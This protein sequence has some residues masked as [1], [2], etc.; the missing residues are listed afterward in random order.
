MKSTLRYSLIL[1]L[2]VVCHSHLVL[3]SLAG[4]K[5]VSPLAQ[6]GQEAQLVA[7]TNSWT[8]AI[9]AKDHAKLESL[10]APDFMLHAWDESWSTDRATWLRNTYERIQIAEYRHSSIVARIFGE[11]GNVTSKWYWRGTEDGKP[12]EEHGFVLDVWRHSANHWQVVSRIT[13]VLPG[14]K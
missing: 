8:A 9:N 11:I 14:R 3:P 13:L 4:E 5:M 1:A 7:L 2:A 6:T 12:F 10:M